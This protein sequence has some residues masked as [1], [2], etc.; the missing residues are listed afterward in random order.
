MSYSTPAMVR[1]ALVPTSTGS[2]P[3]TV[4]HTA[5]DLTDAQLQDFI[6]EADSQIDSYISRYYATPVASVDDGNGGQTVP[7]PLDYWSRNLAAYNATLSV[8]GSQDLS[9]SDPVVRRYTGTM[10]ALQQV[11]SGK[12]GL[13][14][15]DNTSA[16]AQVGVGHA[17]NP[18]DGELF[19]LDEFD[20]R[21]PYGTG[22]RPGRPW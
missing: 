1:K 10:Q 21:P 5:A 17:V 6:N 22:W 3:T 14:F 12:A 2:V 8:K 16:S 15:P 18:Y 7:H 4:T 19:T 11:A 20:L 9:D 13:P